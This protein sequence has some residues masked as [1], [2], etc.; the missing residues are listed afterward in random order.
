LLA[1]ACTGPAGHNPAPASTG[2]TTP[3]A[4]APIAWLDAP[5]PAPSAG[6]PS[7]PA[8]ARPCTP[9]D[10]P[11]TATY[12]QTAGISQSASDLIQ[13]RNAGAS[14]CT[15]DQNPQLLYTD[16]HGQVRPLPTSQRGPAAPTPGASPTRSPATIAPSETAT[17]PVVFSHGCQATQRTYQ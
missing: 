3:V 1:S 5:T 4:A 6:G 16:Q 17:L 10:L 12:Q 13:L 11:A 14:P 8:P 7:T 9:G 15:L 2:S